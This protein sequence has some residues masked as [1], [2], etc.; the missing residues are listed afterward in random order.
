MESF[1]ASKPRDVP[2]SSN[3][4]LELHNDIVNEAS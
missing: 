2:C 3:P 4:N 1:R